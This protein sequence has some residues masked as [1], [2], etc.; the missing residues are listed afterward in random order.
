MLDDQKSALLTDSLHQHMIP[1][2]FQKSKRSTMAH[3]QNAGHIK[4]ERTTEASTSYINVHFS[5]TEAQ[6]T[7]QYPE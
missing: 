3:Y 7:S 6:R 1:E 4:K 5:R 2:T